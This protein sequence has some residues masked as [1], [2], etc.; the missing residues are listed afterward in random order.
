MTFRRALKIQ[1]MKNENDKK[2]YMKAKLK[3]TKHLKILNF[4]PLI[5]FPT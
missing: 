1:T 2:R 4:P 5:Y 3:E